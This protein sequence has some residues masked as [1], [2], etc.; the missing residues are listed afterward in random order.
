MV[1]VGYVDYGADIKSGVGLPPD[2]TGTLVENF[3][4]KGQ[5]LIY[6]TLNLPP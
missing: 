5:V 4:P 1:I 3:T 2:L 6:F